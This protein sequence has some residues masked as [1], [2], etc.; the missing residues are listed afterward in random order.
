MS[1]EKPVIVSGER[2]HWKIGIILWLVIGLIS[3]S[4]V[5]SIGFSLALGYLALFSLVVF[6]VWILPALIA[7]NYYIQPKIEFFNEKLRITNKDT[8]R[9]F[10]YSELTFQRLWTPWY[11]RV[12][13]KR[14]GPTPM[15]RLSSPDGWSTKLGDYLPRELDYQSFMVWLKTRSGYD[16]TDYDTPKRSDERK[17]GDRTPG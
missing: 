16:K 3:T 5:L 12:G 15:F 7:N 9:E 2:K 6:F 14:G 11:A 10:Q 8:E 17:P 13:G 4:L 1:I